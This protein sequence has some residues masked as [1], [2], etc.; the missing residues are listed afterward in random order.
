[1]T[2]PEFIQRNPPTRVF[3]AWIAGA[4]SGEPMIVELVLLQLHS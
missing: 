4:L 2:L 1:M 3:G